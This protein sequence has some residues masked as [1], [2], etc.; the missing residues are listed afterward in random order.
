MEQIWKQCEYYI[1]VFKNGVHMPAK[2][3]FRIVG[4]GSGPGPKAGGGAGP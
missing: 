1:T 4:P 2:F 3:A